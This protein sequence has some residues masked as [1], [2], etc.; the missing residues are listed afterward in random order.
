[1]VGKVNEERGKFCEMCGQPLKEWAVKEK[2]T[3]RWLCSGCKAR[4]WF[5]ELFNKERNVFSFLDSS[6]LEELRLF[7]G[8]THRT[9]ERVV[10][11]PECSLIRK[12]D[13]E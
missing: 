13:V 10:N 9:D 1:M 5:P 8:V 11:S 6:N 2:T 12:G 4:V 3:N 7:K